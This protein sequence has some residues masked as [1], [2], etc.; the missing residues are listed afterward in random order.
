[1]SRESLAAVRLRRAAACAL[2]EACRALLAM[3]GEGVVHP[4]RSRASACVVTRRRKRPA[5]AL[6]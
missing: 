6:H 2:A 1:M 3:P 4:R 5:G